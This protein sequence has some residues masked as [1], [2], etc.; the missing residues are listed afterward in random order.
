[1][2]PKILLLQRRMRVCMKREHCQD[3]EMFGK[4]LLVS[5]SF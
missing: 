3:L 4:G 1:M 5:I 2:E